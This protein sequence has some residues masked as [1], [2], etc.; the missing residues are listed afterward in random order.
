MKPETYFR[1]MKLIDSHFDCILSGLIS[2]L[3]K[4]EM[5]K[6]KNKEYLK[7]FTM[8]LLVFLFTERKIMLRKEIDE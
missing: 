2:L 6:M 7:L 1:S 3:D 5:N 4:E 8:T